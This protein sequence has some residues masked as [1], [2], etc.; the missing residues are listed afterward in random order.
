[1]LVVFELWSKDE[2]EVFDTEDGIVESGFTPEEVLKVME[3]SPELFKVQYSD[4]TLAELKEDIDLLYGYAI[5][6]ENG[7]SR[8]GK[9]LEDLILNNGEYR[10][11]KYRIK[12]NKDSINIRYKR[13]DIIITKTNINSNKMSVPLDDLDICQFGL[14]GDR[15][16]IWLGRTYTNIVIQGDGT[17]VVSQDEDKEYSCA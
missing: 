15:L 17:V 14:L 11:K 13:R 8:E 3:T 12:A 2:L 16:N 1:M 9:S 6:L 7:G 5:D 4:V 10:C